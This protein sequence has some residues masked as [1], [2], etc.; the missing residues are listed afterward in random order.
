MRYSVKRNALWVTVI[1]ICI[2]A[3]PNRVSGEVKPITEAQ[4]KLEGISEEEKKTLK[5]LFTLTQEIEEM[6]REE[7]RISDEIDVMQ[8]G[9]DKLEKSIQIE[10]DKYDKNLGLLEQVLVSYQRGGPASYLEIILQS[11]DLRTFIK[12]INL[13]KDISKNVG[14]LLDTVEDIKIKLTEEMD[15]LAEKVQ[16]Q[17][18]KKAELQI[19]VKKR[20]Q[21]KKEQ[22]AYLTSLKEEQ[23][24]YEQ[25]LANL[26]TMW[27]DLKDL[28][29]GIVEEFSRII[30]EGYFMEK[31]LNISFS[32]LSVKGSIHEDTFNRILSE[33]SKL[34]KMVFHFNEDNILLEV[35]DKNL[36]LEGKFVLQSKSAIL[37]EVE[38]GS[39]YQMPL[40]QESI[41]ELFHDGPLIID[42]EKVAGG[43]VTVDIDLT[44]VEAK[45][46]ALNFTIKVGFPF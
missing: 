6:E 43:M 31:D 45:D 25:H 39:F 24:K 11:K 16:L 2:I 30:G 44:Q 36:V 40:E 8:D 34:P 21:V 5:K 23:S 42:F 17:E 20:L 46:G 22:E 29:S 41:E 10:Q 7:A 15:K 26:E 28:F 38:S 4:E 9:I 18:D 1:L 32:F 27:Q 14:E 37:F 13:V 33:H 35:P 3:L 12:S 19:Q